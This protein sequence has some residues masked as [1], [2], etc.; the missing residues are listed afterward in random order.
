MRNQFASHSE[1]SLVAVEFGFQSFDSAG[2]EGGGLYAGR[3]EKD[4]RKL[5][6]FNASLV[7]ARSDVLRQ[8]LPS[9]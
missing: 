8:H 4:S 7:G 1:S 5:S 6:T 3:L 2:R 9:A